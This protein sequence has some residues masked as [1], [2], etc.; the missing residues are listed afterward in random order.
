MLVV[1]GVCAAVASSAFALAGQFS[2]MGPAAQRALFIFVLAASLWVSDAIPAYAVGILVIALKIAFLGK[3]GGVFARSERDWEQFVSVLGHPLVW[4][5]FGGFVLAAGME[6]SAIDRKVGSLVLRRFGTHPSQLLLGV[7]SVSFGLSMCL[8]NTATTAMMIAILLPVISSANA[9]NRLGTILVM[10]CAVAAN[11]G[12]MASLIGTP[13][14]AIV[15]GV[16]SEK[17]ID[18][19]F[20]DWIV[21]GL[22]PAVC[23]LLLAWA[24]L[25]SWMPKEQAAVVFDWA[26][27]DNPVG[28]PP[29]GQK[30]V[31]ATLIV[32]LT[33]WLTSQWHGIPTAAVAFLPIVVFTS[34]GLLGARDI[35]GLQYDVLFLLAGGLALGRAVTETGLSDWFVGALP[36]DYLTPS[37]VTY[38][39]CYVTVVLSNFMSNTAATNIL[40]P[41]GAS[42][43][44]GYEAQ[45]AIPLAFGA[46]AAMCLPVATPPNAMAFATGRCKT[47]DFL[48][49][50]LLMAV[51]VPLIGI[52]WSQF[53]LSTYLS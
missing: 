2:S 5:F 14:N 11:L 4:L 42:I 6:R 1:I 23:G 40:A 31:I 9:P 16:L 13:P 52:W 30:I 12:G 39:L 7:M 17:G 51:A 46:S 15:V 32:T 34:T 28:R 24:V 41:I 53:V 44:P 36:L 22:P 33:I 27:L 10:G 47:V 20:L 50:G 37:G 8:S 25:R 35:R 18:I 29:T 3:P 45:I 26:Q 21:L 43:L 38:S 49:I 19:D 48:K